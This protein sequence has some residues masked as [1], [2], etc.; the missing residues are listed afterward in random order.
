MV[1]KTKIDFEV[2]TSVDG[3]NWSKASSLLTFDPNDN[4]TGFPTL[5]TPN[6]GACEGPGCTYDDSVNPPVGLTD[7]TASQ[8]LTGVGGWL[9]YS[10]H[11]ENDPQYHGHRARFRIMGS[12]MQ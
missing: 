11:P 3:I 8:Q 2:A 12:A 7:L 1:F 6:V 10:S 9:F 4:E 5:I